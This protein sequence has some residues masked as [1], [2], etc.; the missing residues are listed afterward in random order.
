M[1]LIKDFPN[2]FIDK[3]GNVYSD[4]S[5]ILKPLKTHTNKIGRYAQVNLYRNGKIYRKLVHRLV[6][7]AFIPNPNNCPEVNHINYDTFDNR[8]ENLEWCTRKQNMKHCFDVYS[9]VRNFKT[10]KVYVN[11]EFV[12]ECKSVAEASR[13]CSEEYKIP[14]SMINKHRSYNGIQIITEDRETNRT[15]GKWGGR[16]P[17]K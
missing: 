10:A 4:K 8:A 1:I 7:E 17:K 13:F 12:K 11:G 14:F 2:Y 5:G 3:D 15:F 6:A 16:K 9:P